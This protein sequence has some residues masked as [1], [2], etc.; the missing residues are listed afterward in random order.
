MGRGQRKYRRK[1]RTFADLALN[2][3]TPVMGLGDPSTDGQ[4][5]ARAFFGMGAGVIGAIEP[6]KDPGLI[7]LRN[8]NA[9]IGH[10]HPCVSLFDR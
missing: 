1:G 3:D 6:V 7:L 10:G 9:V 4:P 8:P 5:K 2:L